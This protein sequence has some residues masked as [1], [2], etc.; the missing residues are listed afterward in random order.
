MQTEFKKG[1]YVP[2][3]TPIL[4]GSFDRQSMMR[5]IRSVD[6]Y[7]D[8]YVPCL[9]SGEGQLISNKEWR[10]IVKCVRSQTRKPLFP[11]IKRNNLREIASLERIA[12]E[13]N[14]E[15]I[16]V[17]IPFKTWKK[18]K[19]YF[20][21]LLK[22]TTSKIII[23]NTENAYISSLKNLQELDSSGRIIAIK[24][25]SMNKKFFAQMCKARMKG[26]ISMRVLQGMEHQLDIPNGCDGFLVSLLNIE[27]ALIRDMFWHPT[28][29]T[30]QKIL[31]LFWKYNLGGSWFITL[32]ALLLQKKIIRSAEEVRM[33]TKP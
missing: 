18:N 27:P 33:T 13:L 3:I 15:G 5:L 24:D 4:Y 20:Q 21:N 19:R 32:K 11:G 12:K 6:N 22:I 2:L 25:S 16:T 29:E 14:C 26:Q 7:V 28:R 31:R 9:S 10:E 23:Y 30:N 17:P 1:L 8:G